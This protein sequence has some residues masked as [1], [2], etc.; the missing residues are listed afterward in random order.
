MVRKILEKRIVTVPEVKEILEKLEKNIGK[1][2]FDSFQEY[3]MEYAKAFAKIDGKAAEKIHNMLKNDYQI[4]E[5]YIAMVINIM[6]R[7]VEELRMIFEKYPKVAK[8]KDS[9]LQEIL[10]KIQDLS[11]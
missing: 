4:E 9:D 7:T 8:S 6:P 3:T 2:S 1:E 10:Y 5:D 11:K